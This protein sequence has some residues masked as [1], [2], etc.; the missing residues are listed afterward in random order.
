MRELV[1]VLERAVL[2]AD[3][4]DITPAL[5]E[6]PLPS[7]PAAPSPS[8][9]SDGGDDREAL[10]EALEAAGWNLSRAAATPHRLR[11]LYSERAVRCNLAGR[12]RQRPIVRDPELRRRG[13]RRA[14]AWEEVLTRFESRHAGRGRPGRE[15][16]SDR[17]GP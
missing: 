5:M 6:L 10:R 8:A 9:R 4:D 1:N 3:G 7:A 13:G 15:T 11:R 17:R 14:L 2:L 12:I 16:A